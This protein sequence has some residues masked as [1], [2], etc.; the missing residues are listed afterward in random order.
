MRELTSKPVSLQ[1]TRRSYARFVVANV[2]L[3]AAG[4]PVLRSRRP[5]RTTHRSRN[6]GAMLAAANVMDS[7]GFHDIAKESGIDSGD[8]GGGE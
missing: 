7:A 2:L 1:T 4:G 5:A 8:D 3:I 6:P